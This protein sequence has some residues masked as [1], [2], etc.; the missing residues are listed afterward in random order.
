MDCPICDKVEAFEEDYDFCDVCGWQ[1]DPF[2]NKDVATVKFLDCSGNEIPVPKGIGGAWSSPNHCDSI[3]EAKE[4]WSKYKT[5][6]HF[7]KHTIPSKKKENDRAFE[8]FFGKN[9]KK[10][11]ETNED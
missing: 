8:Y 7:N 2:M 6:R 3:T 11:N 4:A 9:Y 5:K 1:S 10:G